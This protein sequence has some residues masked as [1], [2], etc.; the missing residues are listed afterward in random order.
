MNRIEFSGSLPGSL[1][2]PVVVHLQEGSLAADRV[3]AVGWWMSP[4]FFPGIVVYLSHWF[5]YADRAKAISIVPLRRLWHSFSRRKVSNFLR[6]IQQNSDF[7]P[8]PADGIGIAR[9]PADLV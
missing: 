8:R 6:F 9:E 2:R 3:L 1:S 4:G 7:C 5:R